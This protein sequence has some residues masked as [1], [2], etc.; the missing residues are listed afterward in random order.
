MLNAIGDREPVF[1]NGPMDHLR[2]PSINVVVIKE[3]F[4]IFGSPTPR[5]LDYCVKGVGRYA[6]ELEAPFRLKELEAALPDDLRDKVSQSNCI[7]YAFHTSKVN[8]MDVRRGVYVVNDVVLFLNLER[9]FKA[10]TVGDQVPFDKVKKA[11]C[12]SN[13]PSPINPVI[14]YIELPILSDED[15]INLLYYGSIENF[16]YSV[17]I[18]AFLSK[19]RLRM[20]RQLIRRLIRL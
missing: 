14:N 11:K 12:N 13:E 19:T 6:E 15:Y 9:H 8:F 1:V 20:L 7:K 2:I 17:I 5:A 3:G 4:S 10:Y 16:I 18:G